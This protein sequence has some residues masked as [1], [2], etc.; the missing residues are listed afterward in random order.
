MSCPMYGKKSRL[1]VSIICAISISVIALST[2]PPVFGA[3]TPSGV[4][5]RE[6]YPISI[7]NAMILALERNPAVAIQRLD[8]DVTET[9]SSEQRSEFDP[10]ISA[11]VDQSQTK[12]QR[13]LGTRP[14]PVAMTWDRSN[15][16]FDITQV[17][18]TGTTLS[19]S[20]SMTG[21]VSSLYTDQFS[22]IVG[23][24]V[25]QSLLRGFGVGPSLAN[26]RKAKIDVEISKSELQGVAERLISDVE[27][28]YWNLYLSAEEIVIQ[29]K[30]L[31]LADKQLQESL[32]RVAVGKLPELELAAVH[33]EVAT[34]RRTLIDAQSSY[35][36]A[37]L[38]FLFLLFPS[39]RSAWETRPIPVDIPF[40]PEDSLDVIDI[41]EELGMKYRPDLF[42]ARLELE[43]G[44]L[45]IVRTKN[46]LLPRL[47]LFVSMGKTTYSKTFNDAIP[48]LQSP[49]HELRGGLTFEL[50]VTNR[51][52]RSQANRAR[53][54]RDQME[55]SLK[56]MERLVQMDIR[57]AYIEVERAK[58]Q[59][60]ATLVSRELQEKKLGAEEEKFRV[61]K[62]TNFLVL[63]AQ[64]DFIASQLDEAGAK[65]A[66]LNALIDLYQMEGTLLKRRGIE[67]LS[68]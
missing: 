2:A 59:I 27:K 21:S 18:P 50:P 10:S 17:L 55:L 49:F 58:Q 53:F 35:D 66:Y 65:V 20:A 28:A 46:G 26:L 43:K 61:G 8:T 6:T 24:S 40:I 23:V 5:D 62:S 45:D 31:E 30:S 15:Y 54:T 4:D 44:E 52:A 47:D 51:Q 22:G 19:A 13:F 38:Q 33:A 16:N 41:H 14:D 11:T 9:M 37:R 36:Q 48:D 25:T 39:E 68:M 7:R 56:N 1:Y 57:S 34:R 12:L 3:E 60:E 67:N 42:Q 29:N 64:R 63:Q 32:E